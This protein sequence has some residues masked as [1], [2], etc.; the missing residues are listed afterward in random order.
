LGFLHVSV[1]CI[2][3]SHLCGSR[4]LRVRHWSCP[5]HD[6]P[7][8]SVMARLMV[9]AP[10]SRRSGLVAFGLPTAR[11]EHPTIPILQPCVVVGCAPSLDGTWVWTLAIAQLGTTPHGTPMTQLGRVTAAATVNFLLHS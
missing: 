5:T 6:S 11:R 4:I 3:G 1:E 9:I 8:Q 7:K 10:R 2:F